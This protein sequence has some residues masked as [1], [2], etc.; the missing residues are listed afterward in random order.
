MVGESILAYE[1]QTQSEI[2]SLKSRFLT[3]LEAV[4]NAY[5]VAFSGHPALPPNF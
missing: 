3:C 1:K 4:L 5:A 2:G